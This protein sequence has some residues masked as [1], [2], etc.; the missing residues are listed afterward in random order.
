MSRRIPNRHGRKGER[1]T[2]ALT[3]ECP[4]GDVVGT[5][6]YE[7]GLTWAQGPGVRLAGDAVRHDQ[8]PEGWW[9]GP[10]W[11]AVGV[12]RAVPDGVTLWARCDRCQRGPWAVATDELRAALADLHGSG[13]GMTATL[14]VADG[15]LSD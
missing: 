8:R 7:S 10:T 12:A 15:P 6:R 13:A 9:Q 11:A 14:R 3:V 1:A 4:V 2:Y 5:V